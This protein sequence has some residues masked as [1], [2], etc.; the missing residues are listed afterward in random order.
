MGR[1]RISLT[2]LGLV[3]GSLT[4]TWGNAS[5]VPEIRSTYIV[6][7]VDGTNARAE[8]AA[9]R[10]QNFA[11]R[12]VYENLFPGVAVEL[13]AS[14]AQ[15][16][17]RNPRVSLV[18][19]EGVVT[20]ADSQSPVTWGLDRVDQRQLPLNSIYDYPPSP[21]AGVEIHII[22]TGILSTHT[23]L[24]GRVR[25]GFDAF[26]G[27]TEDCNG[28]G[29]HVAGTT[30]GTTYGLAKQAT[31]VA[32][33]VLGCNGSGAT[34]GVIAGMDW[35]AANAVKPAVANM[36]LGGGADVTM[37]QA[38]DRLVAAGVT[39]V[40]AAGNSNANACNSSPARAA[41][42]ITVG[43][44]T[45]TDAR[46]SFSNYGTCLDIFAPGSSITSAWYTST[47]ATNTISGTS[48]A[49]PHVA[50]AAA[51]LLGQKRSATPAQVTAD[52][53][54]AATTGVV[55]SPGTGSPNRLL[56]SSPDP[57]TPQALAISTTSLPA[58]RVGVSYSQTL[59]AS[60]G[61]APY[62]W[63][64]TGLDTANS[65]LS[66]STAGVISGT[67]RVAT[68]YTLNVSVTDSATPPVTISTSMTLTV[69]PPSVVPGAFNKLSPANG[70]TGV[71]RTSLALSWQASAGAVSYQV[72]LNTT[73]FCSTWSNVGSSTTAVAS[74][75]R[76]RTV[77]YWQVRAV[78][79]DG[80]TVADSGTWWRFTTR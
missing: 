35:V 19:P 53:I 29:T 32:V 59:Q 4:L 5:A 56:Y 78:N 24:S 74:S 46:S 71:S 64:V 14:A 15:A 51:V 52:I 79:A 76:S 77:Y 72:C 11:V 9:L 37:D 45:N 73:T 49:S 36:S 22:D 3:A 67:P 66:A 25:Q 55:T 23:D 57:S 80:T 6:T 8:A 62:S 58:G 69:Q 61:A 44:T 7:Y 18:E 21:G 41:S 43:A 26:G 50:G 60:G 54:G 75:L 16:L 39:V 38:V 27:N 17:S 13:P 10:A 12:Y 2:A 20:V 42:A 70:T 63:T 28:H 40:V 33:R 48:M 68:T 65:G 30:A 34:S 31:V 47:T 1:A